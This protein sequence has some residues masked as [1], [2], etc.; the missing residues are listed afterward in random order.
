M[1]SAA[2]SSGAIEDRD[3]SA[4]CC[5]VALRI[6]RIFPADRSRLGLRL[7]SSAAEFADSIVAYDGLYSSA[8]VATNAVTWSF[9]RFATCRRR[10]PGFAAEQIVR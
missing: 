5:L 1:R 8:V 2:H 9:Y 7:L 4:H 6:E 10:P 3:R